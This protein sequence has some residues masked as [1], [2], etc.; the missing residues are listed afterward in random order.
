MCTNL[1]QSQN[2]LVTHNSFS[3]NYIMLEANTSYFDFMTKFSFEI[4]VKPTTVT[5]PWYWVVY[6]LQSQKQLRRVTKLFWL[7]L[8]HF[9]W[10][11]ELLAK[12]VILKREKPSRFQLKRLLNSKLVE[13]RLV[14]VIAVKIFHHRPQVIIGTIL[15]LDAKCSQLSLTGWFSGWTFNQSLPTRTNAGLKT[16][17]S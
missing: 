1:S 12:V 10:A 4:G 8:V 7:A 6:W 17:Q 15:I 14:T 9:R 11:Q 3:F 16:R 2:N 13:N 5:V